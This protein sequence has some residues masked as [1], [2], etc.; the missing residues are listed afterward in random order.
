M[1]D[2]KPHDTSRLE[3]A[4]FRAMVRE[5]CRRLERELIRHA[6]DAPCSQEEFPVWCGEIAGSVIKM[7]KQEP[8]LLMDSYREFIL[9]EWNSARV[10]LAHTH[11]FFSWVLLIPN[12]AEAL[13]SI[14]PGM[15]I[16]TSALSLAE[17]ARRTGRV[18]SL[19]PEK[20]YRLTPPITESR[21]MVALRLDDSEIIDD[22]SNN[23]ILGVSGD[24]QLY[25]EEN[26]FFDAVIKTCRDLQ[27][28]LH[29]AEMLWKLSDLFPSRESAIESIDIAESGDR[30]SQIKLLY[31][32]L[33]EISER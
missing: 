17:M 14:E 7:E 2:A 31:A 5:V 8:D 33:A 6:S 20:D 27:Y 3:S 21:P 24:A 28:I 10:A 1:A 18:I 23:V 32:E 22:V 30:A 29:K 11:P 13:A 26:R 25:I 4:K 19:D 16:S 12:E 15:K 9:H